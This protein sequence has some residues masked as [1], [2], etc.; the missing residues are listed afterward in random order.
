MITTRLQEL[1]DIYKYPLYIG[2]AVLGLIIALVIRRCISRSNTIT[3]KIILHALQTLALL[4]FINASKY[5]LLQLAHD[6]DLARY[7]NSIINNASVAAIV[8]L[9][10][11]QIFLL[12]NLSERIQIAKGNDLTSV[13][14]M[15]R[16]IKT[17]IV[18]VFI[19]IFGE[20]LGFSVSGLLAFGGLGGIIIGMAS[21]DILSNFLSG[22]MLFYNRQFN[23]G[24][25]ISSPDREIQ[26]TVKEIGWRITKIQT[27]DNRPL[28]VPNSLFSSISVENPGRMTNRRIKTS[29]GIRR[30]DAD[31]L[32]AIVDT[33]RTLIEHNEQIDQTQTIL[34]YFDGFGDSSLNILVYCFTKT[35]KWAEWLAIQQDIYL[36]I[37]DIIHT[38]GAELAYHTQTLEVSKL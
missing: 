1:L 7:L 38:H 9:I 23:I 36:D 32:R 34:V 28:Y 10:I 27:F 8:I 31:K 15:S 25:W 35:T 26:G 33:I 24:D 13:R 2:L 11:W 18:C 3:R 29:V 4:V 22:I 30:Q 6:L 20:K 21:K 12:V 5:C 37:I 14:M 16:I 17:A 19:I